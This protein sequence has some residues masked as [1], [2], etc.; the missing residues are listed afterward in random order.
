[1][2]D[3]SEPLYTTEDGL[4]F[5]LRKSTQSIFTYRPATDEWVYLCTI[6]TWPDIAKKFGLRVIKK[7]RKSKSKTKGQ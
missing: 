3:F 7:R 5:R 6:D 2:E 4:Q 1:M